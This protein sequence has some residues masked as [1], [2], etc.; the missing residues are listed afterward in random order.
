[1][2]SSR[3][4]GS[5]RRWTW[6]LGSDARAQGDGKLVQLLERLATALT[7]CNK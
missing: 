4:C 3:S 1:M 5:E 2:R 7:R 6:A